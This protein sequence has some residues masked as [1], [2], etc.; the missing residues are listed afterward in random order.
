MRK[1]LKMNIKCFLCVCIM[2]LFVVIQHSIHALN[3]Q[4]INWTVKHHPFTVWCVS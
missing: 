2:N 1:K 3:P 4:R